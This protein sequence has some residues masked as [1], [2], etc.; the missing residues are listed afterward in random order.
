MTGTWKNIRF[1]FRAYQ[2]LE[3]MNKAASLSFYT[4]ISIFPTVLILATLSSYLFDQATT[5]KLVTDFLQEVLPYQS[6]LILSNIQTLMVKRNAFSWVGLIGL[7]VTAQIL[8]VNFEKIVNNLLH[9]DKTRNYFLTRLLFFVWMLGIVFMQFVPVAFE[10]VNNWLSLYFDVKGDQVIHFFSKSGFMIFGFIVF[11]VMMT[12]LPTR[13]I[14]IKR[15]VMGA[16]SFTLILQLGKLL[17]KGIT[18]YNLDRYNLIYGSLSSM[19]LG[20]LW[21]FYFYNI[22]LFHVYWVGRHADP[23]YL[24]QRNKSLKKKA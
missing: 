6:E 21:V 5:T 10:V 3:I 13:R 9:A 22:F 7:L 24:E 11:W 1:Y 2:R 12:V 15:L 17:F 18:L 14:Q 16:F 20:A 19:I 4:I 23:H 8:Y